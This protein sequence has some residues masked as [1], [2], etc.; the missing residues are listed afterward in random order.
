[1]VAVIGVKHSNKR[2]FTIVQSIYLLLDTQQAVNH[3]PFSIIEAL[4]MRIEYV[5]M[6]DMKLKHH[7]LHM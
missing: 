1:M 7:S 4:S 6:T 5:K 2:V 3:L